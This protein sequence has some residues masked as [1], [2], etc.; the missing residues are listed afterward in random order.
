M[1]RVHNPSLGH[2]PIVCSIRKTQFCICH[3]RHQQW[4]GRPPRSLYPQQLRHSRK[5]M[6]D[7]QMLSCRILFS[8]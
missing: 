3:Y 5:H 6:P 2:F 8:S 7:N 1:L 4:E